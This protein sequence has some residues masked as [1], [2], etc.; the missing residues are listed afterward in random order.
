MTKYNLQKFNIN[1]IKTDQ[2]VKTI[3]IYGKRATGKTPLIKDI[4]W[5]WRDLETNALVSDET[6]WGPWI[7]TEFDKHLPASNIHHIGAVECLNV[8]DC[9]NRILTRILTHKPTNSGVVIFDNV[10]YDD[11]AC[12]AARAII[13]NNHVLNLHTI[14]SNQCVM[15]CLLKTTPDYVFIYGYAVFKERER[16]FEQYRSVFPSFD[17]FCK[18]LDSITSD[19][20]AYNCLV[21]DNTVKSDKLEDRVYW[22]KAELREPFKVGPPVDPN[23]RCVEV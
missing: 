14:V 12:T 13:N 15:S 8:G 17:V 16:L 19:M 20:A 21:I 4:L 10:L 7:N 3:F 11:D 18:I 5:N 1:K 6:H 2:G 9:I 23:V 22:Y